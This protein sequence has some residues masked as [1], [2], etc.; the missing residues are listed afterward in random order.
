MGKDIIVQDIL[1][2]FK[3]K[4]I[5]QFRAKRWSVL[6]SKQIDNM[7]RDSDD[8]CYS[9]GVSEGCKV[10]KAKYSNHIQRP[11]PT[12]KNRLKFL[13]YGKF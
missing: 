1:D 13:F 10:E 5:H 11:E 9:L 6:M 3:G 4:L 12:F 8:L 7:L 2:I